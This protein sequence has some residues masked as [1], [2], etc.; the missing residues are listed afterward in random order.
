MTHTPRRIV[1]ATNNPHKLDEIRSIVGDSFE[2]L[3]LKEIG[4][5]EDIPETGSTLDENSHIKARYVKTRYGYDC[6]ADDTGLE[7]EALDGDPGVRSARYAPGIGHDSQAN[8]E[9]LLRNM[10][11]KDDRRARFRTVI[12]LI[13]DAGEQQVEGI[14]EGHIA[15]TPSGEGGFGYDPVFVPVGE[16]R[17]FAL[18][19]AAE[20]NA[21]SHRGRAV[22]AL[23]PLLNNL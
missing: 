15:R 6:F 16:E 17:S 18:M 19:S 7:V 10:A 8:M 23:L 5:D 3:S 4:C 22:A 21:I 13:T 9:L 11:G 1:F 14:V 20:K 2:I 12:T